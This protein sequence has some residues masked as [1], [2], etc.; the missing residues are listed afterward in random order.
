MV[1]N[2]QTLKT[3]TFFKKLF[4]SI[5]NFKIAHK[6]SYNCVINLMWHGGII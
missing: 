3:D 1:V 6:Q 4:T 2:I 5:L